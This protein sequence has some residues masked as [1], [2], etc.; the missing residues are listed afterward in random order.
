MVFD[1][2]VAA[3]G[4]AANGEPMKEKEREALR[5]QRIL[6]IALDEKRQPALRAMALHELPT[7]DP[8]LTVE[9]LKTAISNGTGALRTE[10]I[11]TLATRADAAA[12][13]ELRAIAHSTGLGAQDRADA[14][15][16][17]ALSA[18]GA[19]ETAAALR[20]LLKD[21]DRSVARE[22]L[23]ALGPVVTPK[24][25]AELPAEIPSVGVAPETI[26]NTKGDPVAG[27]RLFF[28]PA[29]PGCA[30]CHQVDRRGRAIGPDLSHL[31]FTAAQLL[32]AIREPSKDIAPAF[33][34]WHVKMKDGAEGLGV[35][36]FRNDTAKFYLADATGKITAYRHDQVAERAALPVSMMPP[37]LLDR[38]S[39]REVADLLAFLQQSR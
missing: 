17:L 39:V 7:D 34:Y 1:A 26:L 6:N 27:R 30:N 22:A 9:R 20:S 16:G 13:A 24:D 12:Q 5:N 25:L 4:G 2:W 3:P 19:P 37:G 23:R 15:V 35:D 18:S 8:G 38:F 28:H 10:A 31:N 32:T 14:I 29:G 11:R 21:S 33:L 36:I